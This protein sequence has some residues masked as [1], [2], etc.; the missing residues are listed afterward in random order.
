MEI[1]FY[2]SLHC[3]ALHNTIFTFNV[4]AVKSYIPVLG[5]TRQ[6]LMDDIVGVWRMFRDPQTGFWC[7]NLYFQAHPD[8][9]PTNPC[10]TENDLYSGAGTGM[11]LVSEAIMTELGERTESQQGVE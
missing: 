1:F 10:G 11:G 3:T 7:D 9:P 5:S 8:D 6:R 4:E 2:C